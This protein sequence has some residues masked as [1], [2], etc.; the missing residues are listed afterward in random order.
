M[1]LLPVVEGEGDMKAVPALI[2]NVLSFHTR[3][4]V[5]ILTPHRRG[6][7]PAVKRQFDR[8]F[9]VA[10]VEQAPIIWVMDFDCEECISEEAETRW[11]LDRA[12][13]L[14]SPVPLEICFMVKE[15]ESLFL[16]DEE[17][18]RR[19]LADIPAD[20]PFPSNPESVR[21]AKGWLSTARPKGSAYKPTIHQEKLAV[22]LNINSLRARSDSFA[23]F[24]NALLRLVG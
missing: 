16:A 15:F 4:D 1:K 19:V 10:C 6:E 8:Y 9:Q 5:E 24:E 11:A 20:V 12:K 21:D 18:T 17:T 7:W 23:R 2:R 3:F 14:G 13:S 22:Q